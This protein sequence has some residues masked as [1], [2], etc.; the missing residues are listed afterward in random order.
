[1]TPSVATVVVHYIKTQ[2]GQDRIS[3]EKVF[4]LTASVN[5]EDETNPVVPALKSLVARN[6]ASAAIICSYSTSGGDFFIGNDDPDVRTV[7]QCFLR[8]EHGDPNGPLWVEGKATAEVKP[9]TPGEP[10]LVFTF[11]ASYFP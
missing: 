8:G 2:G 5:L 6:V 4:T 9:A 1:M 11:V 10:V 7:K 3:D